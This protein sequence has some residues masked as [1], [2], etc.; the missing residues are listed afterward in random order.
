MFRDFLGGFR[1][2]ITVIITLIRSKEENHIIFLATAK[3]N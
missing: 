3:G 1:S 2:F